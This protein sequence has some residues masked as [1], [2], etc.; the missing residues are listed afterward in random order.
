MAEWARPI[1]DGSRG[2]LRFEVPALPENG[3]R[4]SNRGRGR[5]SYKIS[6]AP[7]RPV[8]TWTCHTSHHRERDILSLE[9]GTWPAVS[10]ASVA[11]SSPSYGCFTPHFTPTH[12]GRLRPSCPTNSYSGLLLLIVLTTP[13]LRPTADP[14]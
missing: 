10:H 13:R 12:V 11:I 4:K 1:S 7:H 9:P 14:T 3:V 2:M 5:C 6:E 8:S